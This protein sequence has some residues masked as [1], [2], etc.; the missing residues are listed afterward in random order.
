MAPC[1]ATPATCPSRPSRCE[2]CFRGRILWASVTVPSIIG[3]ELPLEH[4]C[5]VSTVKVRC[6]PPGPL[7]VEYH[8]LHIA[9]AASEALLAVTWPVA[10]L[11]QNREGVYVTLAQLAGSC[12][13]VCMGARPG[14]WSQSLQA[15]PQRL[16]CKY[17][18]TPTQLT[19]LLGRVRCRPTQAQLARG[20]DG[21]PKPVCA[22]AS[23]R[24]WSSVSVCAFAKAMSSSYS[25]SAGQP[26]QQLMLAAALSCPAVVRGTPIAQRRHLRSCLPFA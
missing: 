26:T 25:T 2:R 3:L 11:L 6:L 24:E 20:C 23:C 1:T 8:F 22:S 10:M 18:A 5:R 14:C 4:R 17:F 9:A 12:I 15:A 13:A 19:A 16:V 21:Q 7:P